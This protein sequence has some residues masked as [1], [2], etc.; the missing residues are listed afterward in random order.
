MYICIYV[1]MYICIFF[2]ILP[3]SATQQTRSGT[4]VAADPK[5]LSAGRGGLWQMYSDRAS[6][7]TAMHLKPTS[8]H[9]VVHTARASHAMRRRGVE[10]GRQAGGV[11]F[12]K[13]R[14]GERKRKL[15]PTRTRQRR[16]TTSPLGQVFLENFAPYGAKTAKCLNILKC[17][18]VEAGH[19]VEAD[20][21]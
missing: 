13:R 4:G 19:G 3:D 16:A 14:G 7:Y 2:K 11:Q 1:Y 21:R 6:G 8:T 9:N 18:G 15:R 5:H 10:N 12:M 17:A 20:E